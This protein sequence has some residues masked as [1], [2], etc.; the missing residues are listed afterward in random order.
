MIDRQAI[1]A[2]GPTLREL[3]L[4]NCPRLTNAALT[5]SLL[6]CQRLEVRKGGGSTIVQ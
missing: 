2:F 4:D 3:W 1:V 5:E 6:H